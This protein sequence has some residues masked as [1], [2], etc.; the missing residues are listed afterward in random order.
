MSVE[1][2]WLCGNLSIVVDVAWDNHMALGQ[3]VLRHFSLCF[4]IQVLKHPMSDCKNQVIDDSK[5]ANVK[6]D[7]GR[8]R[9]DFVCDMELRSSK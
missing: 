3:L 4:K 9:P 8:N 7:S 2:H 1:E 5:H 6:R